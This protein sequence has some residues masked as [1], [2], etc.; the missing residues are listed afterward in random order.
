REVPVEGL[1]RQAGGLDDVP[2]R[3]VDV[4]RLA[5]DRE[6]GVA[7]PAHL[8]GIGI[9]TPRERAVCQG[10]LG[11]NNVL[12]FENAIPPFGAGQPLARRR[13]TMSG[14]CT[15][16]VAAVRGSASTTATRRGCLYGASR[17]SQNVRIA[18]ASGATVP[19]RAT[20]TAVTIS[21]HW[22]SGNPT[23]ATSAIAGWDARTCS[24][25][26]GATVSPPVR[27]TSRARPTI[28]RHPSSSSAPRSPVW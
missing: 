27:M 12:H 22:G 8:G 17:P 28:D 16:P 13:S 18:A 14:R 7:E 24:T 21:P 19:G 5:H 2:H 3:G 11:R 15:W 20:T 26:T 6:R 23:T 10:G 4:A 9:A 1:I 25:S